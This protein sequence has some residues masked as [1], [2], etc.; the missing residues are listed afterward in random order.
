MVELHKY[1]VKRIPLF[2]GYRV[3]RSCSE[4]QFC[5]TIL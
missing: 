3:R 4:L 2:V 1:D 5:G